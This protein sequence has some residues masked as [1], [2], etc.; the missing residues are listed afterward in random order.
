M[1]YEVARPEF[2]ADHVG[3][4]SVAVREWTSTL[5]PSVDAVPVALELVNLAVDVVLPPLGGGQH[6]HAG[7]A[8]L[9]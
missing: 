9:L 3:D 2:L 1:F 4:A 7:C 6:G 5:T 8:E